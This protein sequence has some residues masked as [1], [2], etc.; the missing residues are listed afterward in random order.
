MV[1]GLTESQ[2]KEIIDLLPLRNKKEKDGYVQALCEYHNDTNPSMSLIYKGTYAGLVKCFSCGYKTN[3]HVICKE[4]TGKSTYELLDIKNPYKNL[5]NYYTKPLT[6]IKKK[7]IM[8][9][10]GIYE[11]QGNILSIY[12]NREAYSYLRNRG[13]DDKT[14]NHFNIGY[15]K[16]LRVNEK[17]YW[18]RIYIPVYFKQ[19]LVNIE[20]RDYLN[21]GIKTLYPKNSITNILYDYDNLDKNKELFVTEGIFDCLTLYTL[22]F[23]NVTSIFGTS[24]KPDQIKLLDEFKNKTFCLDKDKAGDKC[25]SDLTGVLKDNFYIMELPVGV[26][27]NDCIRQ[28]KIWNDNIIRNKD[29]IFK[30]Y[31]NKVKDIDFFYEKAFGSNKID[32]DWS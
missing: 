10:K 24:I 30:A 31:E 9:N 32:F 17:D 28:D 11:F 8:Y 29:I 23:R 27:P 6:N 19:E 2:I 4:L 15:V 5:E 13:F 1:V 18:D 20:F 16:N 14:I 22:G 26:D 25:I 7:T 3:I 21:K 12:D